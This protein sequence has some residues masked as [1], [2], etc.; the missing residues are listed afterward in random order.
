MTDRAPLPPLPYA[1]SEVRSRL[2]GNVHRLLPELGITDRPAG[3][4]VTP[5]NPTRN[6]RRPG[7]FVIWTGGEGAGAWKDYATDEHGD[8]I[9]LVAYLLGLKQKIDAY[10]WAL[11]FLGLHRGNVRSASSDELERA[12]RERD[13]KAADAKSQADE[14]EKSAVLFKRWL[15][16]APIAGTLAEIYLRDARGIPLQ[17]LK[18]TPGALRFAAAW[19]HID[20]ETGEVTTWPCMVAA[21]TR[22]KK[23]VALHR[24][25]LARDGSGKADVAKAKMMIGPSRASAIRLA[26]GPSGLAPH[27]AEA[28]GVFGPLAI[29]EGIETSLTVAAARP[30]YRVWAAGSLSLM[31]L[32]DWPGCASAVVLLRDNDWKAEARA[33]FARVETHWRDQANGR[34]LEVVASAHGSDFNDWARVA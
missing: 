33:A 17:R 16:L 20:K 19:D 26:S 10:W 13:R 27:K 14:A 15:E 32:L 18:R 1:W 31:G 23:V 24:T 21:M 28:A 34:P 7:S 9:D 22:G 4:M 12:R 30:D 8:V 3:G 2:Q 5:R 25:F 6:D 11:E 29:G